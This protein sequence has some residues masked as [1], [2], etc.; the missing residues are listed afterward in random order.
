MDVALLKMSWSHFMIAKRVVNTAGWF[1]E[2][3]PGV[4][5]EDEDYEARLALL[6]EPVHCIEL[7]GLKNISVKT[8]DFSYGKN[9]D[10]VK[11]KYMSANKRFFDS[12]WVLSSEPGKDFAY[13]RIL[14]S[15]AR[16]KPGMETP[17][18]YPE[19]RYEQEIA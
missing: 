17:D 10:V 16:M 13:V 4:G 14:G 19:I 5:N 2:R 18:F 7:G 1:D 8:K 3:F 12:K 15:Y 9:V 6:G 11:E